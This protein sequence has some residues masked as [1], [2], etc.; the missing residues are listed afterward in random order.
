GSYTGPTCYSSLKCQSRIKTTFSDS[1]KPEREPKIRNDTA[2]TPDAVEIIQTKQG[3]WRTYD[4]TDGLP[5]EPYCLLQ[6]KDGY[7]WIGTTAGLCRYDGAEFVIY[8]TAHGLAGNRVWALCEDDQGYLWIGT[9][10]GLCRYDGT[11]FVIY[12]AIHE[13]ADN[14]ARRVLCK[15]DQGK[16]WIGTDHGLCC[17]DGDRFTTYTTTDGLLDDAVFALCSGSQGRI[18]IV[19][20]RGLSCFDGQQFMT[21]NIDVTP[22]S[23]IC[24]DSHGRL[25]ITSAYKGK[26]VYCFDGQQFKTYTSDDGLVG[27]Q[28]IF[29]AVYEDHQGRLWFG[30]WDG[31]SCF[32]GNRFVNYTAADGLWSAPVF[33]ITEDQEGQMWFAHGRFVG[34]SC[35]DTETAQLLTDQSAPWV[36]TQDRNGRIWFSGGSDVCGIQLDLTSSEVQQRRLPYAGVTDLL[37]DS[38]DRLW[39]REYPGRLY[40]Y[41]S[42]DAAWEAA[43]G[44]TSPEPLYFTNDDFG[45]WLLE[46][47]DGT[48]WIAEAPGVLSHFD[49]ELPEG[50]EFFDSIDIPLRT[51]RPQFEDSQGRLW[52]GTTQGGAGLLCWDGNELITYTQENGLPGNDIASVVEDDSGRIWVGTTQGLCCFDGEQFI[53]YSEE[54][55][56]RELHHWCSVKDASGQLWFAT[57]GG[58]YRHDG[59]HFQWLT[60]ADGLPSNNVTGLLPQSD[61]SMIICT[62]RG[63]VRYQSTATIPPHVEIREVVADQ[64]YQNPE[65]LELTTTETRLLTISYH[66][67]SLNTRKMRYS[68]ILEGHDQALEKPEWKETWDTQVRYENLPMG[69]YTF[70]VIA[71]NRD[72]VPSETPATMKLVVVHDPRDVSISVLQTEVSYL[73]REAGMKYDF[74]N[75]IGQSD[76]I[77][78]VHALMERAID[79]GLT[80][81]ITGETG[82]GKELVAKAIHYNSERKDGPL[83][84]RNC[85]AM[86]KDLLASDLFG[87]R[88][89]AFTGANEEKVGL[90]E[91]ASGG[92]LLL[93]EV[94]EMPQDTQAYLL[95]VLE[96]RK[97]QRIGEHISRDV[98]VRII[99]MTNRDLMKEVAEDRFRR[100]LYYR[101]S[102]FPIHVPPLRE[103]L[104]DIPVLAEHFLQEYSEEQEKE[105]DGF[106]PDVFDSFKS[107]TWPGNVRELRNAVR[108]AAALAEEGKQI[109]TYHFL[110][111]TTQEESQVQEA[112]SKQAGYKESVDRFR[113]RFIEEILHETDGN[114]SETARRL[115][116]DRSNLRSLMKRL[117]IKG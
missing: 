102:V 58:I 93:D 96:E 16:I 57:R 8:T 110:P 26:G 111:D 24:E 39:I 33:G 32:D 20:D 1:A 105:L 35:F 3:T 76:G 22:W 112:L 99:A 53:T 12:A 91:A 56:L 21:Y 37:A 60:E 59:K 63:V 30:G 103:R 49:P 11:E 89:G 7:L 115:G 80:V 92:T 47:K 97:V 54:Y 40:R 10:T 108:R 81:L 14:Y 9:T 4:V 78:Q 68:Y 67:L 98:D 36:S 28:N 62:L 19:T 73:R 17:F 52:I 42:S 90:F 46:A 13:L 38:I 107:Y 64:V 70:K 86:P 72:L 31:V 88:K 15:D 65:E 45:G 79:S 34:L 27:K 55:G 83:K 5:G 84:D 25:W 6:D 44:E 18:W 43:G 61:G 2:S 114:R 51:E 94:T 75:I 106:A 50:M 117:G 48:V 82:T 101:L 77:R 100:D 71:I 66:A 109:Q 69:E 74:E 87:H 29:M 23:T 116:M 85:G 95:R 113:R 41:D 104:E